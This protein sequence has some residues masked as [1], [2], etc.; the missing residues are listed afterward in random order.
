MTFRMLMRR[1][2]GYGL[3]N[4]LVDLGTGRDDDFCCFREEKAR[5][6]RILSSEDATDGKMRRWTIVRSVLYGHSGRLE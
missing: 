2:A 5:L 6:P 3:E 1:L 4:G